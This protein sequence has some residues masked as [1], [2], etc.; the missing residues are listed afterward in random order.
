MTEEEEFKTILEF[1]RKSKYSIQAKQ[2][3]FEVAYSQLKNGDVWR[4]IGITKDCL[5][6]LANNKFDYKQVKP[7]RAHLFQRRE[8]FKCI[9]EQPHM[10]VGKV[11]QFV[12]ERDVALLAKRHENKDDNSLVNY[13]PIDPNLG[14]FKAKQVGYTFSEKEVTHL[15]KLAT[16]KFN[17]I[18][19]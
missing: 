4:V 9:L 17:L 8:T 3:L 10:S 12:Y 6:D 1:V 15:K 16:K 18:Y 11:I 5:S 19:T 7:I 14:L 13:A 2:K